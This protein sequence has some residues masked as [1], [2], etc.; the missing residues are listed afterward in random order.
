MCPLLYGKNVLANPIIISSPF[1]RWINWGMKKLSDFPKVTT[2]LLR[3]L[4]WCDE[5]VTQKP[6]TTSAMW[7]MIRES[8]IAHHCPPR[9]SHSCAVQGE[10]SGSTP[11]SSSFLSLPPLP[12]HPPLPPQPFSTYTPLTPQSSAQFFIV[13]FED[14]VNDAWEADY[15]LHSGHPP[16]PT[17]PAWFPPLPPFQSACLL[18][19]GETDS[20]RWV[21]ASNHRWQQEC[22][23]HKKHLNAIQ[24]A[25]KHSSLRHVSR[26]LLPATLALEACSLML[27]AFLSVC[28]SPGNQKLPGNRHLWPY[29]PW[30]R[31]SRTIFCLK[32][33]F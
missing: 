4:G 17:A 3:L 30:S 22:K 24:V 28:R 13:P 18:R 32:P 26:T 25:R 8:G 23:Q 5:T 11:V 21:T 14:A 9:S 7:A 29:F 15:Q 20:Q 27:R 12:P 33:W 19:T 1:Y 6:L 10:G 2:T 31:F 16:P